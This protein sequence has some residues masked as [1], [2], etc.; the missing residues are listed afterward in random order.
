MVCFKGSRRQAIAIITRRKISRIGWDV[1]GWA[2][3]CGDGAGIC[4][5][6]AGRCESGA[7]MM[8]GGVRLRRCCY[9]FAFG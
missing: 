9:D 6:G 1:L 8:M 7:G 4:G 3:R 2:W 5:D